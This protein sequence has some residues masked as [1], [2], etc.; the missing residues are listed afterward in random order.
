MQA[1]TRI[2][3]VEQCR[4]KELTS[5]RYSYHQL[6]NRRLKFWSEDFLISTEY[7]INIRYRFVLSPKFFSPNVS[8]HNWKWAKFLLWKR[9]REIWDPRQGHRRELRQPDVDHLNLWISGLLPH[10]IARK[11]RPRKTV[12]FSLT[13]SDYFQTF[14]LFP[15]PLIQS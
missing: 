3:S 1:K 6:S 4:S 11:S 14:S 9:F 13:Y 2:Y 12:T 7:S 15:K 10:L 5:R 8:G